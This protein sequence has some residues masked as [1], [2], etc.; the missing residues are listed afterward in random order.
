MLLLRCGVLL[1]CLEALLSV[2][3]MA[4]SSFSSSKGQRQKL[5]LRAATALYHLT[6]F[7]DENLT[8]IVRHGGCK[9]V[10]DATREFEQDTS[11]LQVVPQL[12]SITKAIPVPHE[13][14]IKGYDSRA[15]LLQGYGM[16]T[17]T[18]DPSC[19]N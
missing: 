8:H 6:R 13:M 10:V 18:F 16:Q 11:V 4:N 5:V 15:G 12:S 9:A 19:M 7:H 3:S 1:G 17:S 2:L 14:L